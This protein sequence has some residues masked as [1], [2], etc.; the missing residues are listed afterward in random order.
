ELIEAH[1]GRRIAAVEQTIAARAIP[2]AIA[3]ELGVPPESPGLFILRQYRDQAGKVVEVSASHHPA[4]RYQFS[5]TL[6]RES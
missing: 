3:R 1:Y 6:I 5:F 2:P 4:G